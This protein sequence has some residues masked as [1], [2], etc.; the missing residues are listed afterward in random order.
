MVFQA[1]LGEIHEQQTSSI[2]EIIWRKR[3]IQVTNEK[4]RLFLVN[5]QEFQNELKVETN[6]E[7]N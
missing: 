1:F 3:K 4:A 2:S 7:E 5:L 6:I